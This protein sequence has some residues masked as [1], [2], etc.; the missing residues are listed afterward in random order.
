MDSNRDGVLDLAT[1]ALLGYASYDVATGTWDLTI[2]TAGWA[3]GTYTLFAR[4]EDLHGV[5]N[6]P[7][8]TT[9]QV[10]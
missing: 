5:F 10:I 9:V 8:A 7:L 1:D 4:A 3:P 2:S 6:D